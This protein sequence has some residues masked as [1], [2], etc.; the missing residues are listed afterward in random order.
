MV[1]A[2]PQG[3]LETL[4]SD[5]CQALNRPPRGHTVKCR[6]RASPALAA[7][8]ASGVICDWWHG[9]RVPCSGRRRLCRVQTAAAMYLCSAFTGGHRV[10][11]L[12]VVAPASAVQQSTSESASCHWAASSMSKAPAASLHMRADAVEP[13]SERAHPGAVQ[14]S[15]MLRK[16]RLATLT[17]HP[18]C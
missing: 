6:G 13:S 10:V 15:C 4:M 16:D 17:R 9:L 1:G 14:V 5:P 11:R 2:A 18:V 8:G 3:D 7:P 12:R